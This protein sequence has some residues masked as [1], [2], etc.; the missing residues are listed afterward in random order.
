VVISYVPI[1]SR[2][3]APPKEKNMCVSWV[4]IWKAAALALTTSLYA[5]QAKSENHER[6]EVSI[7][8]AATLTHTT[9]LKTPLWSHSRGLS[10]HLHFPSSTHAAAV[11]QPP[12]VDAAKHELKLV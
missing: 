11:Q 7:R 2:L 4:S 6:V 9:S 10:W 1:D 5:A 3:N 12:N 8:R